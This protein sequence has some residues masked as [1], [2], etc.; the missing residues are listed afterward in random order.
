[1]V[2]GPSRPLRSAIRRSLRAHTLVQRTD[3]RRVEAR[4]SHGKPISTG[5]V[6]ASQTHGSA[7]NDSRLKTRL[8]SHRVGIEQQTQRSGIPTTLGPRPLRHQ[9]AAAAPNRA[10]ATERNQAGEAC[11][12]NVWSAYLEAARS[13]LRIRSR[14]DGQP[15]PRLPPATPRRTLW[16]LGAR[17]VVV[18]QTQQHSPRAQIFAASNI[19]HRI[20]LRDR[21]SG[22]EIQV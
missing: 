11:Q 16:T 17:G 13:A 8:H 21:D 20:S 1:V 18:M 2:K 7:G 9:K 10:Q 15:I 19:G 3:Q 14:C 12:R 4:S 22:A 6:A 5:Y